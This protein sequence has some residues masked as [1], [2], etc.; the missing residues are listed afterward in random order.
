MCSQEDEE[1]KQTVTVEAEEMK[2]IWYCIAE[3]GIYLYNQ[4]ADEPLCY[5]HTFPLTS[6]HAMHHFKIVRPF[7]PNQDS[8]LRRLHLFQARPFPCSCL[9]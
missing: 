7:H 8:P 6:V 4:G 5:L 1:K 3:W 9:S 2:C